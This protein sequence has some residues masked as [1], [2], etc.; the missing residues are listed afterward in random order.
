MFRN[1]FSG[2]LGRIAG[3]V[4]ED[5]VKLQ[6]G[7]CVN[8]MPVFHVD[9]E[10][11]MTEEVN[12]SPPLKPLGPWS[13]QTSASC[14]MCLQETPAPLFPSAGDV[15]CLIHFIHSLYTS[16]QMRVA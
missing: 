10:T 5:T 16:N 3:H 11:E 9:H 12:S 8:E 2:S 4:G 7:G 13:S 6:V 15:L 14:A 1:G